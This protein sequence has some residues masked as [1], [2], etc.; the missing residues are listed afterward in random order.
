MA[1]NEA[2][3]N[4]TYINLSRYYYPHPDTKQVTKCTIEP[5]AC[6]TNNSIDEDSAVYL[7]ASI[8]QISHLLFI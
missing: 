5:K 6:I 8:D 3:T 1:I 4:N 2:T 7:L